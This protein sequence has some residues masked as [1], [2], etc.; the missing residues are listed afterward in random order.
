MKRVLII[1]SIFLLFIFDFVNA[2]DTASFAVSCTIPAI[3]GVNVPLLEQEQLKSKSDVTVEEKNQE[4][5]QE[6]IQ[7]NQ[8]T[9]VNNPDSQVIVKTLYAR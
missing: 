1:T 3:P 4:E 2:G 8:T 7:Q 5:P 9:Q 6:V